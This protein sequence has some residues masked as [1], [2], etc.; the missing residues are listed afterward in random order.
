MSRG[1]FVRLMTATLVAGSTAFGFVPLAS[2]DS[3]LTLTPTVEAWYQPNP[4]CLTPA[5]CVT[6]VAPPVIPPVELP[7][8]PA[9]NPYPAGSLHVG[10]TAG[11][12]TARSYL[13]FPFE[14]LV[15]K[16]VTG[17]TLTVPLDVAPQGGS[18]TPEAS[19]VALCET[20]SSGITATEG[21]IDAPPSSDCTATV[22]ATYVATPAPHLQATLGAMAA[23]LPGITGLVLLPDKAKTG[24]S[25]A[26]QVAF[27]AH[28]RTDAAKTAPASL[29]VTFEDGTTNP[30]G[31]VDTPAEPVVDPGTGIVSEPGTGFTVPTIQAPTTD[32][33]A[34]T[35]QNPTEAAPQA[36]P[37]LV[38][39]G[40]AY[41]VVWLLPLA[42]L[43]LVPATARAITKDLTA[44]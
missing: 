12:E 15:G 28:T 24:Q 34:P 26:W 44:T 25:D 20:S 31:P 13:R 41:P 19:K 17:A 40:Y 3:D 39:I 4:T 27:S 16:T 6:S 18:T 11:T 2:A 43:I 35:V 23:D 36:E 33:I 9:A 21:T 14:Q 10:V 42:F 32:G 7:S 22:R 8:L 5:G 29:T 37:K 1:T 30:G 38:T